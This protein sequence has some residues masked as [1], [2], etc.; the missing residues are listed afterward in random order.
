MASVITQFFNE[1]SA[2]NDWN[3]LALAST[4]SAAY[5]YSMT[6]LLNLFNP[7]NTAP[8][9]DWSLVWIPFAVATCNVLACVLLVAYQL[10]SWAVWMSSL[11]NIGLFLM[12][13][14]SVQNTKKASVR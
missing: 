12:G 14:V 9:D 11:V 8:T 2:L 4:F 3:V 13:P 6:G 1:L 5:L 7:K 10:G